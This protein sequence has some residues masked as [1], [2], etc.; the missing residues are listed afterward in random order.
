M[1]LGA[2]KLAAFGHR[3]SPVGARTGAGLV[4]R[5]SMTGM[6]V[7]AWFPATVANRGRGDFRAEIRAEQD[8]R[9]C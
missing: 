3:D 2:P 6:L 9:R 5:A 8:A 7:A 1:N 4:A